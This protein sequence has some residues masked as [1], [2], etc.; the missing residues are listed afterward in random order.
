MHNARTSNRRG[1]ERDWCLPGRLPTYCGA[2]VFLGRTFSRKVLH[3]MDLF[4]S[5]NGAITPFPF[6]FRSPSLS[7]SLS[8]IPILALWFALRHFLLLSSSL[9]SER[10]GNCRESHNCYH[11]YIFLMWFLR[12]NVLFQHIKIWTKYGRRNG[13][14][15]KYKD[16][17]DANINVVFLPYLSS[18]LTAPTMPIVS[19]MTSHSTL[20][21]FFLCFLIPMVVAR[22]CCSC[23]LEYVVC[24]Y[25]SLLFKYRA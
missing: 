2:S 24:I 22:G 4:H 25:T 17:N 18:L 14:Y 20:P 16:I 5:F 7:L 3:I 8:L 11:L 9:G 13:F 6:L 10:G 12:R 1:R 21:F 19:K 15:R 23:T